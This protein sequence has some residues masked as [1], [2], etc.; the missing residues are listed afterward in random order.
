MPATP[1]S[2]GNL[3]G[4]ISDVGSSVWGIPLTAAE[5]SALDINGWMKYE[6][7]LDDTVVKFVRS[8]P[9]YAGLASTSGMADVQ[10]SDSR[11]SRAR[12]SQPFER[13]IP[14]P[15]AAFGWLQRNTPTTRSW[16]QRRRAKRLQWQ[17][18]P[19]FL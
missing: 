3:L 13:S 11:S 10:R 15:R 5:L 8:L 17:S 18:I 6:G 4:S 14:T 7:E 19:T 12:R 2:V 16:R 1:E 9:T